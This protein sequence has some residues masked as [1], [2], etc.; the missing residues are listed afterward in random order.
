[1]MN[2][3]LCDLQNCE[4]PARWQVAAKIW[5][6]ATRPAARTS[7]NCARLLTGLCVCDDHRAEAEQT[8]LFAIPESRARMRQAFLRAGGAMPD[9]DAAE[10]ECVGIIDEPISIEQHVAGARRRGDPVFGA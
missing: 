3:K 7:K 10:I 8:D 2:P 4:R 5:A 9:L 1:M 6:I